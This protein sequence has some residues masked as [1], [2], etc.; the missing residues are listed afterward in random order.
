MDYLRGQ[1]LVASPQLQDPN[2]VHTVVLMIEHTDQGALGVVLNR[3]VEKTVR[4]LFEEVGAPACQCNRPIHLG[5]PVPGPLMSIH[6]RPE[7]AEAEIVSGVFLSAK[8]ANLD[9]LVQQ[10]DGPMKMFLGNSGWGPG[11]LE[12]ELKEGAWLTAPASFEAVFSEDRELWVGVCKQI[13]AELLR[14]SLGI[15]E[16]PTDPSVN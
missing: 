15:R 14:D 3:P 12:R 4:Q 11:Q 1:L 16:F 10:A 6:T 9:Q 8:K 2:F 7:L 13:G 5:G